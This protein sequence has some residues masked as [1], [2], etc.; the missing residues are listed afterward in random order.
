MYQPDLLDRINIDPKICGGKPCIRGTR[1]D[2][3]VI[4]DGLAEGLTAEQLID[5]YPQ[6]TVDDI[7]AALAYAAELS[8][9]N[10]WKVAVAA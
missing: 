2:I 1:I 4:L 10:I 5:H 8:R 9:E 7:R 3:A 6:L